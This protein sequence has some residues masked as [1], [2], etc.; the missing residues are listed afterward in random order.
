MGTNIDQDSVQPAPNSVAAAIDLLEPGKPLVLYDGLLVTDNGHLIVSQYVDVASDHG[1]K[2]PYRPAALVKAIEQRYALEFSPTIQIS[3]PHRFRDFGEAGIQDDQEGFAT[4][5]STTSSEGPSFEQRNLEQQEALRHLLESPS[6]SIGETVIRDHE[7]DSKSLTFGRSMWI[8]CTSM[9]PTEDERSRWR[10]SLPDSY[11]HESVIRQPIRF[12]L[13][14]ASAFA[15]QHGPE[16]RDV[17]FNHAAPGSAVQS[18]HAGQTI[19]HGPV[20][21]TD[22][23]HGFLSSRIKDDPLYNFYP[24][25]VKDCKYQDQLEYRFALHCESPVREESLLLQIKEDMR[26]A[27]APCG[28]SSPVDFRP[29]RGAENGTAPSQPRVTT[30]INTVTSTRTRRNRQEARWTL[31]DRQRGV[32][33]QEGTQVMEQEVV[34]TSE[35]SGVGLAPGADLESLAPGQI[36][37][38]SRTER[39]RTADGTPVETH[40]ASKTDVFNLDEQSDLD[41]LFELEGA[42]PATLLDAARR[43]FSTMAEWPPAVANLL[44][45]LAAQTV[46]LEAQT[47]VD[48]MSACWNA[49][50]AV[51]NIC[52]DFGDIVESVDVEESKFVA[53]A[54]KKSEAGVGAKIL[55]GPRG[56]FAY[57]LSPVGVFRHGGTTDRLILFPDDISRNH[58]EQAGWSLLPEVD[59]DPADG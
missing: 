19:I 45:R 48:V 44:E 30:S 39:T 12:A 1:N 2:R 10:A 25:F 42:D 13:A 36:Q 3:C 32:V 18:V 14:L 26:A 58:F 57:L 27:L 40:T 55:V 15:D 59:A 8:Y 34:A 22:D 6:I 7:T 11:R 37:V 4:K 33:V 56:T 52:T 24:L 46:D 20:W 47:E 31:T 53:I 51:A 41:G 35:V 29:A 17:D 49:I 38:T 9:Y 23:V 16:S 28:K 21:Y 54:L 5:E 43:P 50:W